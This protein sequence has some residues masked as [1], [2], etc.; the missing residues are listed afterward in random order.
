MNRFHI[1]YPFLAAL[2][3]L[4]VAGCNRPK[5]A[6]GFAYTEPAAG[7]AYAE[8]AI[9]TGRVL[10]PEVY[11]QTREITVVLPF[12]DSYQP[13]K[14]VAPIREDGTFSLRLF[15]YTYRDG[16]IQTFV[17]RFLIA[18]GDSLH[19]ELDF[20]DLTYVRFSGPAA[21]DNDNLAV[22]MLR[23]CGNHWPSEFKTREDGY[24][25]PVEEI[26]SGVGVRSESEFVEAMGAERQDY[27]DRLEAFAKKHNPSEELL[28]WC[29]REIEIGYYTQL[30]NRLLIYRY[31]MQSETPQDQLV[32]REAVEDLFTYEIINSS[33]FDLV[34]RYQS[35][36]ALS[37]RNAFIEKNVSEIGDSFCQVIRDSVSNPLLAEMLIARAYYGLLSRNDTESFEKN[38][39]AFNAC[40]T[41]P[42]L[43]VPIQE[44]YAQK[45][46]YK[47]DPSKVSDIILHPEKRNSDQVDVDVEP[48]PFLDLLN[49]WIEASPGQVLYISIGATWCEPCILQKQGQ[50]QL[51]E[52]FK[53][54]PLRVISIYMDGDAADKRLRRAEELLGFKFLDEE[55]ILSEEQHDDMIRQ[56]MKTQPIPY[57]ILIDKQGRIVDYGKHL[58]V[59]EGWYG[60]TAAEIRQ[61]LEADP[62]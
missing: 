43:T 22:F 53:G 15:P 54:Q 29:R 38:L 1:A 32:S 35:W 26:M 39:E 56:F 50:N 9:L 55:Y 5:P 30:I 47:Q 42:F 14:Y 58:R 40:V 7:F 61:L 52:E 46:A 27:L 59:E 45:V 17:D 37:L 24:I 60:R 3:L 20:A 48:H 41:A 44:Y 62:R 23:C 49:G 34:D 2:L 33:Q 6:A 57:F 28:S 18:P 31:D 13:Q 12:I 10:H 51:I 19:V 11:P 16:F 36:L 4:T 21:R 8:P 25:F